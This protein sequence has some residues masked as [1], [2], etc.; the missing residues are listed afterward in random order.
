MARVDGLLKNPP[1]EVQPREFAVNES[2]RC[3]SY[4]GTWFPNVL[5]LF[6]NNNFCCFHS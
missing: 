1:I 2:F 3:C 6:Y 4:S 5:F